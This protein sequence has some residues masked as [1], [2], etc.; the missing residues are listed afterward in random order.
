[1]DN[2]AILI[3]HLSD[4]Y[5]CLVTMVTS[6]NAV[7]NLE[8]FQSAEG[9]NP[10]LMSSFCNVTPVDADFNGLTLN[11]DPKTTFSDDF[12]VDK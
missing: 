9:R 5:N 12:T 4:R 10:A 7:I 8:I 6:S 3:P 1:M 2:D 11:V